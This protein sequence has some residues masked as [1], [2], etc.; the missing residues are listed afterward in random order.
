VHGP[1]SHRSGRHQGQPPPPLPTQL[2]GSYISS[3]SPFLFHP[4]LPQPFASWDRVI[5]TE[6]DGTKSGLARILGKFHS[7]Q[8]SVGFK[9]DTRLDDKESRNVFM[10]K[11]GGMLMPTEAHYLEEQ[12]LE[13]RVK[14]AA[15]EIAADILL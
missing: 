1:A 9:I 4:P 14:C 13:D 3:P 8:I 15:R 10:L 5:S 12:Y 6:L 7:S 11:A 2:H